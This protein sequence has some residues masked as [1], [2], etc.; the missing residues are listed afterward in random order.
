MPNEKERIHELRRR[1]S[2]LETKRKPWEALWQEIAD[3][4]AP[5]REDLRETDREG[6]LQG[7]KIYD[8]TAVYALNLFADGLHGYMIN[9]SSLWF[10]RRLPRHLR[11]LEDNPEVRQWLEDR[12][13]VTYSALQD[14]NFY[15]EMRTYFRDGGSI[16]TAS[17]C[18]EED[19]ASGKLVFTCLH[20]KEGYIAEDKYGNVDTFFR[21][22]KK[23]ARQA[24]QDFGKDIISDKIKNALTNNPYTEFTFQH[25][26]FPRTNFDDR[27]IS[28]I[29]KRFAS[30]W[31]ESNGDNILRESGYN[32]FPYMVWRYAKNS[33]ELYGRSP[34]SFALVEIKGLNVIAKSLLKAGEMSVDPAYN[35]PAEMMGKV[36]LVPHGMNYYGSDYNRKITPVT[37]GITYPI[38]LDREEKKREIIEKHFHVEIF[39]MLERAERE[40]TA[41]E[42][43]ER[44]GEKA[45]VLSASI[46][47]LTVVLDRIIDYVDMIETEAG[48]MPPLPDV[49]MSYAMAGIKTI[50]TVYMGPLAQAQKRL[51][52]TQGIR[53]GLELAA[54][55]FTLSPDSLDAV[56]VDET[57]KEIFMSS[58][59]PQS[60]LNMPETMMA[61]RQARAEAQAEQARSMQ[62]D[63]QAD[64]L[65]KLAM[66]VKMVGGIEKLQEL[67]GGAEL[68]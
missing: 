67:L 41:R 36:R 18:V 9:P 33:N 40:M 60:C 29:N 14:S 32:M 5:I 21:K 19:F 31:I 47:D 6:K 66:A 44:M 10:V 64:V 65:K 26:V 11:H 68:G 4:V 22:V 15:S 43:M 50:D 42:V 27:K 34:A 7:T 63:L 46:G 52:E 2:Y 57:V 30:I 62:S 24:E 17:L 61:L 16:G 49:L 35:I 13:S 58:G 59:F 20:P 28:S 23:T 37:T 12:Q 3:Y 48:R 45:S 54:P 38:A 39:L 55:L 53:A 25:F 51:F 8:G 1:F 56:N